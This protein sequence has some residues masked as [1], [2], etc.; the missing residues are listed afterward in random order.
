MGSLFF[1]PH[2]A[3]ALLVIVG[4]GFPLRLCAQ[5]DRQKENAPRPVDIIFNIYVDGMPNRAPQGVNI[6]LQDG[7]GSSEG[8]LRTDGNG[9]AQIH[10]STGSHR[11][12]I[13][14]PDIQEYS[15][16]FD[17]EQSE[18]RHIENI[19]VRSKA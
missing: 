2:L 16:N 12:R 18:F 9:T 7:F 19:I 15:N 11:L 3:A 17:V 14:G 6:E 10:S 13:Y 4:L 1:R 8:V 5:A